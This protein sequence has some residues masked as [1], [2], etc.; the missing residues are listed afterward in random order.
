MPW[1]APVITTTFPFNPISIV[2][3]LSYS[4]RSIPL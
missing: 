3:P 2:Y 4:L 1:L